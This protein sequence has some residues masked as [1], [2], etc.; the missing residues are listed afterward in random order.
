[1]TAVKAVLLISAAALCIIRLVSTKYSSVIPENTQK[2]LFT[3]SLVLAGVCAAAGAVWI[4]YE[5]RSGKKDKK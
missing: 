2:L 4:I 1:M 3:L 5:K